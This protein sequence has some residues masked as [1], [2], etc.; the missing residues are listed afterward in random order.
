M[1][2]VMALA[3]R[4]R[5]VA[6]FVDLVCPCDLQCGRRCRRVE[7]FL[8]NRWVLEAIQLPLDTGGAS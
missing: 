1:I 8:W 5:H 4:D 3:N 6:G 2:A 7:L